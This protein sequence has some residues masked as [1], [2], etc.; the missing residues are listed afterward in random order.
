VLNER[1]WVW[2]VRE[3][4]SVENGDGVSQAKT[5]SSISLGWGNL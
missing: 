2:K 4:I 1:M 3:D 5:Q